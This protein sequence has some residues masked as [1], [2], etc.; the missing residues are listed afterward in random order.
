MLTDA[1]GAPFESID[2]ATAVRIAREAFGLDV[3]SAQRFETERD[4]TFRVVGGDGAFALKLAHPADRAD[5]VDL[6]VACV[7][8]ALAVDPGLPLARFLPV[9]DQQWHTGPRGRM[10]DIDGRIARCALWM[11]GTALRDA[12]RSIP[13]IRAVAAA[14]TRLSAALAGLEHPAADRA[15][16]WDLQRLPEL[17]DR[18]PAVPDAIRGSVLA[19]I[20]AVEREA[21]PALA[22]LPRQLVHQDANLDNLLVADGDPTA[23][24]AILDF[25]DAVRSTRV[26]DLAVAASYLLPVSP[27]EPSAGDVLDAIGAGAADVAA[28]SSTE[29]AMLPLLTAGRLAQR[30][31]LGWWL[32]AAAPPNVD[33]VSR[34]LA[35]T[36]RQLDSIAPLIRLDRPTRPGGE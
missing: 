9:A 14:M 11:P 8:H 10:A 16:A 35:I 20:D 3:E 33:Y 32:T 36:A 18:A 28:L 12:P 24:A 4:D 7:E 22:T 34:S 29:L 13:Q 1:L 17:R 5:D 23:V 2:A 30:L 26:A 6:E 25:G 19:V 31:V 15:L 27:D 21:V